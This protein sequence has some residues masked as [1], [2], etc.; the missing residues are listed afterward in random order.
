MLERIANLTWHRPKLV[1][2]LVAAFVVLAG[3]FGH[4]VEHHLK[5]AGFTDS[6]SESERATDAAARRAGL[7][8]E[9]RD[10]RSRARP[11]RRRARPCATRRSGAR[12]LGVARE[13]TQ[14][15]YVGRVSNPLQDPTARRLIAPDRRSLLVVGRLLATQDVEDAGRRGGRG[16][17]ARAS[18]TARSTSRMGGFATSFNEVN[19]Q[20]RKDLTN[21]ELIAFPIARDP[22]AA[23]L[24]RGD[25]GRDPLLIGVVSILGLAAGA[26]RDVGLRGHVAVRAEHRDRAQP[27]PGGRLR[28]ADGLALPRG[29]RTRRRTRRRRRTAARS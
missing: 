22:A 29:A 13:L 11:R 12:S 9:P 3:V 21:A 10:R 2:A 24:P 17:Q 14:A 27:R 7:R 5:A 20:T 28:A 15:K 6:A 8:P 23:R 16:R 18:A 26:A 19:D 4:D 25:R 1:L